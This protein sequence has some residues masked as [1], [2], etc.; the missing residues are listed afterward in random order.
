MKYRALILGS[1]LFLG[2]TSFAQETL[3]QEEVDTGGQGEGIS[4]LVKNL[5][6]L[7][8]WLGY[9]IEKP[10]EQAPNAN[11]FQPDE[12]SSNEVSF[13][14]AYLGS[15]LGMENPQ[16][17]GAEEGGLKL[18]EGVIGQ[19]FKDYEKPEEGKLGY[20]ALLDQAPP[21]SDPV[22]QAVLNILS[23]P[24]FESCYSSK[25]E[26]PTLD[27]CLKTQY[28]EKI[29]RQV[30]DLPFSDVVYTADYNKKWLNELNSN[31]LLSPLM[32][33]ESEEDNSQQG[34]QDQ[35]PKKGLIAKTAMEKAGN[36]VR[37]AGGL[38]LPL[39]LPSKENYNDIYYR[40]I[41]SDPKTDS[42]KI[43]SAV[44]TLTEYLGKLKVYSAQVSVGLGNLY[45]I[46]S[47]RMPQ[48]VKGGTSTGNQ[49]TSQALNEF[50]MATW[51]LNTPA[52]ETDVSWVKQINSASSA[53]VQKEIA[54]LLAEMNYQL[55]LNRQQQER[56]LLTESI[57]LFQGAKNMQPAPVLGSP[58]PQ[59]A[60]PRT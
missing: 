43:I 4:K 3:P 14:S 19:T 35:S 12:A 9:N 57:L 52:K 8:A 7:G 20:S 27:E 25:S 55:Y 41:N 26:K 32:Y 18:P 53:S 10:P 1:L 38:V 11:L 58:E 31:N 56:I 60:P 30:N 17:L 22:E 24:T 42:L 34:E 5:R 13:V 45:Y 29:M 59:P 6:N 2:T 50:K 48:T 54:L 44:G 33:T 39:T 51:R 36:F 47:R 28:K 49:K 15:L 40:I 23:T 46:V 21:Q 37:F 16:A